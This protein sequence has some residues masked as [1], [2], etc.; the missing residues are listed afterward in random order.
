[1]HFRC[2]GAI[3]ITD[4]IGIG[5]QKQK[6]NSET[7]INEQDLNDSEDQINRNVDD[8]ESKK[9]NVEDYILSDIELIKESNQTSAEVT[10]EQERVSKENYKDQNEVNEYDMIKDLY[11]TLD[12]TSKHENI[13]QEDYEVTIINEYEIEDSLENETSEV[14]KH[15]SSE[16]SNIESSAKL[17]TDK[18]TE[19]VETELIET[20]TADSNEYIDYLDITNDKIKHHGKANLETL[21]NLA[22][23]EI[24]RLK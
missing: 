24:N 15:K 16:E 17:E 5:C 10:D 22:P 8:S 12:E 9:I 23:K 21:E 11:E 20:A 2:S 7:Q 1:M 6:C 19:P 14:S 13:T 3:W 4:Q 18:L